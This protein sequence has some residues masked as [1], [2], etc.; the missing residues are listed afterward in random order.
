[1]QVVFHCGG[2][3]GFYDARFSDQGRSYE[4]ERRPH[5]AHKPVA[6]HAENTDVN[7]VPAM[8]WKLKFEF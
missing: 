5:C 1:M 3:S 8:I 7:N 2:R 6:V 4:T